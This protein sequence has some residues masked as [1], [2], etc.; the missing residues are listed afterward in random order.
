MSKIVISVFLCGILI[1]IVYSAKRSAVNHKAKQLKVT[2]LL[3]SSKQWYNASKKDKDLVLSLV[4]ASSSEAYV[5][6]ARSIMA[7][8][9]I[10]ELMENLDEFVAAVKFRRDYCV[11]RLRAQASVG[12]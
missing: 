12:V 5:D 6:A 3:R 8:E 9:D 1:A 10:S 2:A 7:D 11:Q 4:H